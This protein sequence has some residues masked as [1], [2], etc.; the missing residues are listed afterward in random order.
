TTVVLRPLSFHYQHRCRSMSLRAQAWAR[1]FGDS[2]A[3][4]EVNLE[5]LFPLLLPPLLSVRRPL[6]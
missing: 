6:L 3:A 4:V 5:P 2:Q 1:W